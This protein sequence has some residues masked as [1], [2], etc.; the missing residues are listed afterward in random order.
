MGGVG[1]NTWFDNVKDKSVSKVV[2]PT[3]SEWTSNDFSKKFGAY[4]NEAGN[5]NGFSTSLPSLIHQK[6][7]SCVKVTYMESRLHNIVF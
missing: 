5:R 1:E 6:G 7:Q 4:F 3:H 2:E